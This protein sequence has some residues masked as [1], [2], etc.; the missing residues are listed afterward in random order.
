MLI[1]IIIESIIKMTILTTLIRVMKRRL[2][3][4]IVMIPISILS[5][6]VVKVVIV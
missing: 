2:L 3:F 4:V 6:I 5:T 1:V